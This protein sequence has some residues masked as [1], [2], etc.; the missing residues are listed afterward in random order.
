M[1][2]HL[3]PT[4]KPSRLFYNVGG[5]LLFRNYENHNGVNIYITSDEE[6]KDGDWMIRG[7][8][9]PTL[10]TPNFFWDFGVRY[11]KIILTTDPDLINDGVQAIDDEFLEWFVKNPSCEEV[12]VDKFISE[13]YFVTNPIIPKEEPKQEWSPT[14]GEEVW[15]K[16]FSNWSKGTYV[17]Y[18]VTKE[19]HIVR[20]DEE[21]GGHLMSSSQVLPY[22]EMP[23]KPKQKTLKEE[24][25]KYGKSL[26]ISIND[27]QRLMLLSKQQQE[28]SYSEEDMREV[29]LTSFLL[30][31]DRGSYS[32]ELE[33]KLIE[34]FKNR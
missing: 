5:A 30:G 1:N 28:R 9:Q 33:D 21:G 22:Y 23:N 19:T 10:V 6:I 12:K 32:K 27:L 17:G 24:F 2:I 26:G 18:D 11:Y 29:I 15:I 3:T 31:V 8:E 20:E 34:Q 4:D 25:Y 14:Q 7:N 16:V 13:R